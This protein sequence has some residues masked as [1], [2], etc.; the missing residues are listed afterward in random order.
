MVVA[1]AVDAM[2]VA[3]SVEVVVED[4]VVVSQL[5]SLKSPVP[6]ADGTNKADGRRFHLFQL[7][8]SRWE[9]TLVEIQ[10]LSSDSNGHHVAMNSNIDSHTPS[11]IAVLSG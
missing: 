9:Q 8:T 2:E 10:P 5:C 7:C 6:S 1:A 4:V 3:D 11:D